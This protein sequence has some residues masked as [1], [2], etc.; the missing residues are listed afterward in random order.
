MIEEK[1]NG[2]RSFTDLNFYD[3]VDVSDRG[4][5]SLNGSPENVRRNFI[6]IFNR[7]ISLEGGPKEVG[8]NYVCWG[9]I[10]KFTVEDVRKVCNV[11]GE[12]Y[13]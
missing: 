2:K 5:T 1:I 7:L 6:C 4:L 10:T 3:D 12:I 11:K 13:C 8:G 9:N